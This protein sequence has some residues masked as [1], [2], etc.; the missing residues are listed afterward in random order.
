MHSLCSPTQNAN[1]NLS[2]KIYRIHGICGGVDPP[3]GI[4]SISIVQAVVPGDITGFTSQLGGG[5]H[6]RSCRSAVRNGSKRVALRLQ[7]RVRL[8][9]FPHGGGAA[10]AYRSW[11]AV[12]PDWI[13][14]LAI[15]PPGR[16]PR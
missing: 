7:A 16:E 9:C 15:T 3:I 11:A 10:Q 1:P 8:I 6:E 2:S 4:P 12:L 14:V 5:L 13:E